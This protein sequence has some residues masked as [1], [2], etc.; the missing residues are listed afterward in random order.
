MSLPTVVRGDGR[1]LF[2]VQS[3]AAEGNLVL[4]LY[5]DF[6]VR[7]REIRGFIALLMDLPSIAA[8]KEIVLNFVA[9]IEQRAVGHVG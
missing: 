6:T 8:L 4:F 9:G 2:G 3:K 7:N 5:I 1:K